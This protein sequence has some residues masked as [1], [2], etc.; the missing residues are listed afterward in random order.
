MAS[1]TPAPSTLGLASPALGPWFMAEDSADLPTLA[2]PNDDLS[3]PLSLN[4]GVDWMP[5]AAGLLSL[6][7]AT[8]LRPA[9]LAAL[10]QASGAPAFTDGRLVALFRL[11]PEVEE[12]LD[13]LVA[14]IPS[15]DGGGNPGAVPTRA[16]VRFLALE[17]PDDPPT[18]ATLESRLQP[19]FPSG[20]SDGEKARHVGLHLEDGSLTNGDAPMYDLKRPGVFFGKTEPLLSFPAATSNLKLWA[21]DA[22]GR[23]LDPGAVAAWWVFLAG[24]AFTNLWAGGLDSADR[25]TAASDAAL[26]FHLVNAHEGPIGEVLL[27]RLSFS[28]VSGSGVVRTRGAGSGAAALSFTPAPDP[29]NAPVPRMAMLPNG[30]YATT[31]NLW[32]SGPV[33]AALAR[34]FVRVAVVD[35]ERHLVG[36]A[37]VSEAASGTPEARRAEDQNRVTTRVNVAPSAGPVLLATTDAAA[38][39]VIG[40][41]AGTGPTRLVT[42]VLDRD[43]AGLDPLSLPAA[44]A[45]ETLPDPTVRALSGG[46][47]AAGTTVVN[48]QVLIEWTL[49]ATLAGAWVRVWPQGFDAQRG[50]HFRMDGGAGL[51][52][53]DGTVSVVVRLPDG[54][55]VPDALMGMDV[56]LVTATDARLYMDQRFTRPAPVGGAFLPITAVTGSIL[57]C[58]TGAV[59]PGGSLPAGVV[60]SGAT[61]VAEEP[62]GPALIALA[63]LPPTAFTPDTIINNL[64]PGDIIE[65]TVPAF[66]RV[67]AGAPPAALSSTGA[68]INQKL[69]S[70][71]TRL[72]EPGAPI[73]TMERLEIAAS[74]VNGTTT[75]AMA[76]TPALRQ[77][78]ELL[79]HQSGH[80]GAPAAVEV[81]G[82]GAALSGPAATLLHEAVLDRTAGTT[83]ELAAAAVAAV[84]TP[85]APASPT[86]WVAVLRTVAAGVEAEPGLAQV[87]EA[88]GNPYPFGALL[89]T[90]RTWLAGQ[91][92]TLPAGIDTAA[93]RVVRALDRRMLITARGAREGATSL[94]AALEH[95]EDLVYIETPALDAATFGPAGDQIGLWQTLLDRL[96]AHPPLHVILCIP[97]RHMPG[98]P[99]PLRRVRD[100]LLLEALEALRSA[101]GDRMAVFAP[102]SGPGRTL[103]LA[104]TTVIVDDAYAITGT[105]HLW[106]RGLSFDSSLAVAVFDESLLGGRPAEI[107][108]FRRRLIANR[109]GLAV[110]LLPADPAELVLAL[111]RLTTQGSSFRLATDAILPPEP[112]PS[113]IDKDLWNRDGSPRPDFDPVGWLLEL[114]AAVRAQLAEEV[115]PAP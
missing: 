15:A 70:G 59:F 1:L 46:G 10:R 77:Y 11:L 54:E 114:T 55:I 109:L 31:V 93:D 107:V 52:R 23:P 3:V 63:S 8:T 37:R 19:G 102:A 30:T 14:S 69:R 103:R 7:V 75:A 76:T 20:M 79:P 74:Q 113:D 38:D 4:A 36:Q 60:T 24:T 27:N 17:F 104:S 67:P 39:A 80:P 32:P 94:V 111:R 97:V 41:F 47:T 56:L 35:V 44:A 65:L 49:D 51:V 88:A 99:A 33:D 87:L 110:N 12:R 21:F 92:I 58:E 25:R 85:A 42:S 48:Q 100:A 96:A 98:M 50:V 61:L 29:D 43:W 45:P 78:H 86:P 81:H 91:G 72:A 13:A 68:T 84:T 105:T 101:A 6:F 62:G 90:I 112:A 57:I 71:L 64:A 66:R 115:T 95:A 2:A 108:R 28:N 40:V 18:L 26:T 9:G 73:P 22:L 16:R 106:R 34:D 89:D 53:S 5:P 83:P 82:T